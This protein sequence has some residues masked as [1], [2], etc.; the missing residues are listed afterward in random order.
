MNI[1]ELMFSLNEFAPFE[2][3]LD[4]D[5]VGLIVGDERCQVHG[6]TLAVDVTPY[7]IEECIASGN[8]TVISHHPPIF[9]PIKRL[10]KGSVVSDTLMSAIKNG[11]NIIAMH[12]NADNA[13]NGINHTLARLFGINDISILLADGT[14]VYGELNKEYTLD[15]FAKLVGERI[16]DENIRFFGRKDSKVGK[17]AIISGSGGKD[18]SIATLCKDKGIDTYISGEFRHSTVLEFLHNGVNIIEF[19][20]YESERIFIDIMFNYLHNTMGFNG[21]IVKC[22]SPDFNN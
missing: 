16:R 2:S 15:N 20:H 14:G 5:N 11:V 9:T 4:F 6:I 1:K 22:L 17:I 8:N 7:V 19:S 3:A 21:E 13:I 12:T 18:D 10:I